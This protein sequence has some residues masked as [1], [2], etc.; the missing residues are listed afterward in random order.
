MKNA[1]AQ[2]K[3]TAYAKVAVHESLH[4]LFPGSTEDD[5]HTHGWG[6]LGGVPAEVAADR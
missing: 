6:R 2:Y 3:Y 1:R 5:T 4:N